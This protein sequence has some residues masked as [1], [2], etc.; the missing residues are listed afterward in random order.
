[1][2]IRAIIPVEFTIQF[3]KRSPQ[4]ESAF[5][6]WLLPSA[7]LDGGLHDRKAGR[8]RQCPA[9]KTRK[10]QELKKDRWHGCIDYGDEPGDDRRQSTIDIQ[11]PRFALG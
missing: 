9:S 7:T 1:M 4:N 6:Y 3:V 11:L 5:R 10:T 2:A 8:E